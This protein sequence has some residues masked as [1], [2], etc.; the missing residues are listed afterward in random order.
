MLGGTI[1]SILSDDFLQKLTS[2]L[3]SLPIVSQ[4]EER[5]LS[6]RDAEQ[7]L[8]HWKAQA[9]E[10]PTCDAD[11]LDQL[12]LAALEERPGAFP[13]RPAKYPGRSTIRR[14]W[15]HTSRVGERPSSADA[16]LT[17]ERQL[18]FEEIELPP[19]APQVFLSHSHLD[20]HFAGR[21]RLELARVGLK[22]WMSEEELRDGALIIEGVRHA[23]WQST[24]VIGLLTRRS[25][26]AAWFD[27][28]IYGGYINRPGQDVILACDSS[29]EDLLMLLSHWFSGSQWLPESTPIA[30]ECAERISR[31]KQSLRCE[32]SSTR[33]DKYESSARY[34]MQWLSN[35]P[36]TKTIYPRMPRDWQGNAEFRDFSE[37]IHERLGSWLGVVARPTDC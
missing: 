23:V 12:L 1:V 32:L 7:I 3:A 4:G 8:A 36:S 16:T 31:M 17:L 25:L 10:G 13:L 18:V 30:P 33:F 26:A 24:A 2:Y 22:A 5:D 19:D 37:V 35:W 20:I 28:E 29:D 21:M 11:T 9:W 34:F 15:G 6:W 27:T 14:L